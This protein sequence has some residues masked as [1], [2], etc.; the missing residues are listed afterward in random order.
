MNTE[1]FDSLDQRF[2]GDL[3]G[4]LCDLFVKHSDN[5]CTLFFSFDVIFNIQLEEVEFALLSVD[6]LQYFFEV[7]LMRVCFCLHD[8]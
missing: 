5:L 2:I 7:E 1:I 4:C 8:D 6:E 3:V